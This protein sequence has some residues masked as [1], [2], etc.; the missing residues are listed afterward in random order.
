MILS[1]CLMAWRELPPEGQRY[2]IK[3]PQDIYLYGIGR[4]F[5][6]LALMDLFGLVEVEQPPRPIVPG[7]VQEAREPLPVRPKFQIVPKPRPLRKW[8][9]PAFATLNQGSPTSS[10]RAAPS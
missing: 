5:Y 1:N 10:C 3:K 8:N 7:N 9:R 2:D 6:H 4:E